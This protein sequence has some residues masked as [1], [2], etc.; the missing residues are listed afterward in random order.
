M[1]HPTRNNVGLLPVTH[2]C[3]GTHPVAVATLYWLLPTCELSLP[4]PSLLAT[5]SVP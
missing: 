5:G 3:S 2:L 1:S 4:G